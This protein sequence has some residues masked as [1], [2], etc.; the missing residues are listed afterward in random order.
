MQWFKAAK[1]N[2]VCNREA[3]LEFY[4]SLP[5]GK[6]LELMTTISGRL[7]GNA[8][9]RALVGVCDEVSV[10]V[11]FRSLDA[12]ARLKLLHEMIEN[13]KNVSNNISTNYVEPSNQELEAELNKLMKTSQGGRFRK[14]RRTRRHLRRHRLTRRR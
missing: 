1:E 5:F 12:D 9:G 4:K 14:H 6:Q 3:V 11:F 2:K 13:L 8:I 10:T 7:Q